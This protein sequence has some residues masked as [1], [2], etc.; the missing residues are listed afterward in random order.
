VCA[1]GAWQAWC[2]H[3]SCAWALDT[4][5]MVF[6]R[7]VYRQQEMVAGWTCVMRILRRTGWK[8][9]LDIAVGTVLML[10][11]VIRYPLAI[12]HLLVEDTS[13]E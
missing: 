4:S 11:E 13:Q 3:F 5:R 1:L 7:L 6:W 9:N 8:R 10:V 12:L 2:L